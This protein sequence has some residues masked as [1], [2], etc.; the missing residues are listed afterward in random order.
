MQPGV[1]M[2]KM[3]RLSPTM[4]FRV[5]AAARRLEIPFGGHLFRERFQSVEDFEAPRRG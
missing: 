5:A 3:Y 1:D 4:Y 2:L